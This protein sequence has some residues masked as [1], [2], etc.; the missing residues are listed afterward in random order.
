V[1]GAEVVFGM[2]DQ[3]LTIRHDAG[4]SARPYVDGA[5][6]AIRRVPRLAGLHRGLDAVLDS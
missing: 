4:A 2:P 6:L 1:I 3:R 5:L